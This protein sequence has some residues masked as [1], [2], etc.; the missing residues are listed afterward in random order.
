MAAQGASG[1]PVENAYSADLLRAKFVCQYGYYVQSLQGTF[2][3]TNLLKLGPFNC[4]NGTVLGHEGDA[5]SWNPPDTSTKGFKGLRLFWDA[6][7]NHITGLTV[8]KTD[9]YT[10]SHGAPQASTNNATLVCPSSMT[11]T[12]FVGSQGYDFDPI[13]RKSTLGGVYRIGLICRYCEL[14][15]DYVVPQQGA[16]SRPGPSNGKSSN[17]NMVCRGTAYVTAVQAVLQGPIAGVTSD[18]GLASLI[19]VTC[20]DGSTPNMAPGAVPDWPVA[21]S[22]AGFT[23]VTISW[24]SAIMGVSLT[25]GDGSATRWQG[26]PISDNI[27]TAQLACPAGMLVTGLSVAVADNGRGSSQGNIWRVG[28]ACK[29][30]GWQGVRWCGLSRAVAWRVTFTWSHLDVHSTCHSLTLQCSTHGALLAFLVTKFAGGAMH[31]QTGKGPS[32]RLHVLKNVK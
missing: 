26:K 6:R 12:G 1:K 23:G 4:T 17:V 31:V 18:P 7:T 32:C 30:G 24:T 2:N 5:L 15:A 16:S 28:L 13:R 27:A 21:K 3:G 10:A 25:R 14:A 11:I 9:G 29:Y 20:S 8:I 19:P 22:A